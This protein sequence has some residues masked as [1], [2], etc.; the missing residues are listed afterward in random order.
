MVFQNDTDLLLEDSCL[1]QFSKPITYK[2]T[3][4]TEKR[5][6]TI[7]T[8]MNRQ[9]I[10]FV[11]S[12]VNTSKMFEKLLNELHNVTGYLKESIAKAG[13][14]PAQV[15][16]E[17]DADRSVG[18][19]NILWHSISF[20]TRGN[21]KPQALFRDDGPPMYSGRIIALKG[22]FQDAALDLQD[23]EYPD[24]LRC[25]IAS[26]FVPHDPYTDV[27]MKIRHL[28]NNEFTL[29]QK[30]APRQF[31]L[32]TIEIICGGGIYHE[33]DPEIDEDE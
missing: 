32:K 19:L 14:N 5:L 23:Q 8:H 29:K 31:L 27:I 11:E 12:G 15:F 1:Y 16:Y 26:L 6:D 10:E 7:V 24:V 33:E 20:T 17:I 3:R 4:D 18:I 2:T 28:S 13:M 30:D 25:E 9:Y 22:D 21:T